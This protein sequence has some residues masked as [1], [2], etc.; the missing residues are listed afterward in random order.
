MSKEIKPLMPRTIIGKLTII[1]KDEEKSE[2]KKTP[3]YFVKCS[4]GSPIKSVSKKSLLDKR[5]SNV[6]CGCLVK[7]KNGYIKDRSIAIKKLLYKRMKARHVNV[8]KNNPETLISFDNFCKKIEKT[9]YYCGKL[10]SSFKK[11]RNSEFIL[12]YNG[13]DRIDSLKGYTD[14]NTVPACKRCNIA[15]NDRNVNDFIEHITL[16]HK[17]INERENNER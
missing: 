10:K 11:D 8:L 9:C 1:K 7:E 16:I 4:C 17:R 3:Y 5:R 15:K 2:T 14:E 13:L 12:Y 6:S